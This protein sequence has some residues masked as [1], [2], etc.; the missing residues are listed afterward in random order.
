MKK[1]EQ[2]DMNY[3]LSIIRQKLKY[4][5]FEMSKKLKTVLAKLCKQQTPKCSL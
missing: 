2:V 5:Q 3:W 4:K 1:Y